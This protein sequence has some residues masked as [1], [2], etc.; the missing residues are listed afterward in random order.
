MFA[1]TL[2]SVLAVLG[3]SAVAAPLDNTHLSSAGAQHEPVMMAAQPANSTLVRRAPTPVPP[4]SSGLASWGMENG[5]LVGTFPDTQWQ[6]NSPFDDCVVIEYGHEHDRHGKGRALDAKVR[7]RISSREIAWDIRRI[8]TVARC[9]KGGE[10]VFWGASDSETTKFGVDVSMGGAIEAFQASLGFS[11]ST[12]RTVSNTH[13]TETSCGEYTGIKCRVGGLALGEIQYF[14][15]WV[16]IPKFDP[17]NTWQT[18]VPE[19]PYGMRNFRRRVDRAWSTRFESG[20]ADW[21]GEGLQECND[22]FGSSH[23]VSRPPI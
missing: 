19:E 16:D 20:W 21:L 3:A 15:G 17:V 8:G 5:V 9:D 6:A 23:Y 1:T 22:D 4:P 7:C 10:Q 14:E 12:E 18:Q 13:S 11:V 2:L